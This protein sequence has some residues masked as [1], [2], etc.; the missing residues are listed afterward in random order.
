MTIKDIYYDCSLRKITWAEAKQQLK[1]LGYIGMV[2]RRKKVIYGLDY[3]PQTYIYAEFL[4]DY[5]LFI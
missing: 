2:N 4:N 3:V 1:N 5:Q